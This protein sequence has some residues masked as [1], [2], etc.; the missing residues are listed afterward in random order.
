MTIDLADPRLHHAVNARDPAFDGV[1]IVAITSTRIY[2]RPV[3]PS[4]A[5]RPEN[6]RFF[7]T[8]TDAEV[9]GYRACKRCRPE[10]SAGDTPLE[11]VPRLARRVVA[12]IARGELNGQSVKALARQL[13]LSDRHVRRAVDREVGESPFRIALAQRIRTATTLLESSA[14]P[15]TQIA[16]ASGFQSVRRFNA[17]FRAQHAMS[18]SEWRKRAQSE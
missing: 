8:R 12:G 16:Y 9:A 2:C 10:R 18:P 4:R 15:V 1:F 6:R 17:A 13:G 14:L 11:A 3:C 7:A 5:A